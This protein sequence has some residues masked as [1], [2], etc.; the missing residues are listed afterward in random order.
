VTSP[1]VKAA[2]IA[3]LLT[4]EQPAIVAKR[5]GLPSSLVRKW[6]FRL[7]TADGTLHGTPDGTDSL[8]VDASGA[9]SASTKRKPPRAV[10]IRP[11]I[12]AQQLELGE[13]VMQSLRAKLVATQRI[14]EY[15]TSPSWLDKQTAADVAALFE[16]IDRSAIGILD[17]LSRHRVDDATQ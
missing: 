11:A 12:E 2:A 1:E 16:A 17:R 7:G 9:S 6:K 14:A 4:G 5:Y 13:L 10:T 8:F 3:D 15:A